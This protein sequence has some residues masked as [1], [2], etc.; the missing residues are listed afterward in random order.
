M[1]VFFDGRRLRILTA[2]VP[3]VL[4]MTLAVLTS[5]MLSS[6][7]AGYCAYY[8]PEHG[9]W[10]C[11]PL[12][13][14]PAQQLGVSNQLLYVANGSDS[15][16][17]V[18]DVGSMSIIDTIPV[19]NQYTPYTLHDWNPD[20]MNWEVHGVVPS[21]DRTHIY[22]VGALS[23][24]SWDSL[25]QFRLFDYRMYDINVSTKETIREIPLQ[26]PGQPLNPVGY[27]GLEY[28]LND[29]SSSEIIAASMNAANTSL[30]IMLH[31]PSTGAPID[32]GG[33]RGA[34]SSA[35]VGGW[36]FEDIT[37]GANTG[38][39]SAETNSNMESSTCGIS[40]NIDGT[41]GYA[42]QMFE[43]MV[44][45]VNWTTRTVDGAIA[46]SSAPGTLYHQSASDK[47]AGRLYVTSSSGNIDVFDM[48]TDTQVGAINTRALTGTSTNDIHGVEIAPGHPNILYVTSRYT[49]GGYD[50]MELVVDITNLNAPQLAGVVGG[51]ARDVCGVYAVEKPWTTLP[52]LSLSKTRTYWGSYAEY[53]AETLSVD[54]SVGNEPGVNASDVTIVGSTSTSG[55]TLATPMPLAIGNLAGGASTAMTLRY[56]VPP[57]TAGFITSTYA[58]AKAQYSAAT[59]AYPGPYPGA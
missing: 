49:A 43:P 16:V 54:Y 3:L 50:N 2:L 56:N 38:F 52:T 26:S 27:C 12:P 19:P 5:G 23:G 45:K 17:V 59:Y 22:A 10:G 9:Y 32:M 42:A 13:F 29:E 39:M 37:T 57:G 25:S 6:A 46:P 51:L 4:M 31:D 34:G 36:A 33:I 58:T 30:A 47:A 48:N 28:N 21:Q 55:V 40:W 15:N 14:P 7:S 35:E 1:R 24:G 41:R 44:G 11:E 18:I 53:L 8:H 20:L